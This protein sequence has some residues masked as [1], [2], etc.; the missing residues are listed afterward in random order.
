MRVGILQTLTADDHPPP[1]LCWGG[2]GLRCLPQGERGKT[3]LFGKD[4]V[5]GEFSEVQEFQVQGSKLS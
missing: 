3:H 5:A 2:V 1:S 4:R